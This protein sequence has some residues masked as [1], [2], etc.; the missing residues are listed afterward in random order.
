MVDP[1]PLDHLF[2]LLVIYQTAKLLTQQTCISVQNVK[3]KLKS[4]VS[5]KAEFFFAQSRE[6]SGDF[7]QLFLTLDATAQLFTPVHYDVKSLLTKLYFSVLACRYIIPVS[8]LVVRLSSVNHLSSAFKHT[9]LSE[10]QELGCIY[11]VRYFWING[12][13]L[14]LFY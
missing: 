10:D 11:S 13:L 12:T 8:L 2:H 3:A 5:Q 6:K 1:I 7:K 4:S 9:K 14:L